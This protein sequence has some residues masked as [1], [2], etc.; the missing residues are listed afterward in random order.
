MGA[1]RLWILLGFEHLNLDFSGYAGGFLWCYLAQIHPGSNIPSL[2]PH[3]KPQQAGMGIEKQNIKTKG[4]TATKCSKRL[5]LLEKFSKGPVTLGMP[6]DSMCMFTYYCF[7][8]WLISFFFFFNCRIIALQCCIGFCCTTT[9]ISRNY[10][11]CLLLEPPSFLSCHLSR[12]PSLAL[13]VCLVLCEG[14]NIQQLPSRQVLAFWLHPQ[15]TLL[16][17]SGPSV[18]ART[19]RAS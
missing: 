12:E 6:V 18:K 10:I 16:V 17:L 13:C 8:I 5:N 19:D 14:R 4:K 2:I 15:D 3:D 9:W 1:E 7:L 11:Y